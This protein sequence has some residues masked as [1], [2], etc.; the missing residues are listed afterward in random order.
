MSWIDWIGDLA[1]ILDRHSGSSD[2]ASRVSEQ[3]ALLEKIP[4][5]DPIWEAVS[6]SQVGIRIYPIDT[7]I[8]GLSDEPSER[9][10]EFM[11]RA[12]REFRQKILD[13][14]QLGKALR[15]I[16]K[17]SS[18][19]QFNLIRDVLEHRLKLPCSGIL[20]NR[21]A[22]PEFQVH[23]PEVSKIVPAKGT[24]MEFR[25]GPLLIESYSS[26]STRIYSIAGNFKP[27]LYDQDGDP[28]ECDL[29]SELVWSD[30]S[31]QLEYGRFEF[32]VDRG[33]VELRD[34]MGLPL[35]KRL[36][37]IRWV[38]ENLAEPRIP[39]TER[40]LVQPEQLT[41]HLSQVRQCGFDSFNLI[42]ADG[43]AI[44]IGFSRNP[45]IVLEENTIRFVYDLIPE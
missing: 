44:T 42:L 26:S 12:Y 2:K 37:A 25:R 17:R 7:K 11:I 39:L 27:T 40:I 21:Y 32:F 3:T 22:P 8:Q 33:Q 6:I 29:V 1:A 24:K 28:I 31:P 14:D 35:E 43:S 18:R 23:A 16:A 19:S 30:P 13:I 10:L 9:S 4:R 38:W 36:K 15:L 20:W 41:E 5:D 34:I 45:Q